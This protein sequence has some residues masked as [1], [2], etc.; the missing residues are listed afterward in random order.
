MFCTITLREWENVLRLGTA[1]LCIRKVVPVDIQY[2]G[3]NWSKVTST[4][5]GYSSIL[6]WRYNEYL[7]L[8]CISNH[9]TIVGCSKQLF[10]A[11]CTDWSLCVSDSVQS[12]NMT[13]TGN[14]WCI[15]LMHS[16]LQFNLLLDRRHTIR[17]VAVTWYRNVTLVTVGGKTDCEVS[18]SVTRQI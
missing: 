9:E 11:L 1:F 15:S 7:V 14:N 3:W 10:T 4:N 8:F 13:I 12:E 16:K 5:S 2:R 6:E 17:T 18:W